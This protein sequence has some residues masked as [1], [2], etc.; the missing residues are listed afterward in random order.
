LLLPRNVDFLIH[1]MYTIFHSETVEKGQNSNFKWGR[2][3]PIKNLKVTPIGYSVS[4]GGKILPNM[5]M[6]D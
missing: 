4:P 2:F 5:L 1:S 6:T 3:R